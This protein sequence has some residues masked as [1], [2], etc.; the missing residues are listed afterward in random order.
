MDTC[1]IQKGGYWDFGKNVT[2]RQRLL[3]GKNAANRCRQ[4]SEFGRTFSR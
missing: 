3:I 4:R 1:A 2:N